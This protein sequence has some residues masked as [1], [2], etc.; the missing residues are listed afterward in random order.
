MDGGQGHCTGGS[1]QDHPH[2]KERQKSKTAVGEA[3]QI[4]VKSREVKSS[5][6]QQEIRKPSSV[7]NA[8]K[9][10][11]IIEWE[12]VEMSSRKLEIPTERFMQR[13][14]Q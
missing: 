2:G 12:R 10:R 9:Q 3:L 7:I 13:W 5:K 4:A 11:K 6:E 1:D 8:K 14:A